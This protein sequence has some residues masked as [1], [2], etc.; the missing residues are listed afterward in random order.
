MIVKQ[1]CL[2]SAVEC[3]NDRATVTQ[4]L[5]TANVFVDWVLNDEM[6]SG[7]AKRKSKKETTDLP[8]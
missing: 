7:K 1:S 3:L 5:E 6:P 2:K 4:I 8:F